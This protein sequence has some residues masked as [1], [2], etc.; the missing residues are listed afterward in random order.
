MS[1]A[2]EVEGVLEGDRTIRLKEPL[3]CKEGP[4]KVIVTLQD[5]AAAPPV[6]NRAALEAL[7]R[8]LAEPDEMT[9]EQWAELEKVIEG[10]PLRIRKG[11]PI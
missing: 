2:Y 4:V 11:V 3:P 5:E 10:H 1:R 9:P 6:A 7:D 8:L